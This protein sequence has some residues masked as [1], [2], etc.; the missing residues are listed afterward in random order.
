ML[1]TRLSLADRRFTMIAS[2][3]FILLACC[4]LAAASVWCT[5]VSSL[6]VTFD[7]TEYGAVGDGRTDDSAAVAKATAALLA[8]PVG[9]TLFFPAGAFLFSGEPV[10]VTGGNPYE[11]AAYI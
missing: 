1:T 11:T 5:L 10:P 9:G 8:S 6:S 2:R 3:S 7:V 4:V